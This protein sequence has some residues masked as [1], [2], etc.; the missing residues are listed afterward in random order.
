MNRVAIQRNIKNIFEK[1]TKYLSFFL[2]IKWSN[3]DYNFLKNKKK[4]KPNHCKNDLKNKVDDMEQDPFYNRE[5]IIEDTKNPK[6]IYNSIW[7]IRTKQK[8]ENIRN[9]TK[10]EMTKVIKIF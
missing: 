2:E 5:E 3:D 9:K 4:E 8:I 6:T 7:N 1:L 10:K